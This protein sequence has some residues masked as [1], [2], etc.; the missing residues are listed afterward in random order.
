MKWSCFDSSC[1]RRN[2][3]SLPNSYKKQNKSIL[4][5]FTVIIITV[6]FMCFHSLSHSDVMALQFLFDDMQELIESL[7]C[8]KSFSHFFVPHVA[9]GRCWNFLGFC[10]V[11][12]PCPNATSDNT[13]MC[14]E[15][16]SIW[17]QEQFL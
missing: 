17:S 3:V 9:S 5:I 4:T 15:S 8:G 7:L 13:T 16:N 11:L 1:S 12:L 10:W 2:E 14:F 6:S